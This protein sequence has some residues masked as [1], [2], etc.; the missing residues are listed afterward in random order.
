M[1]KVTTRTLQLSTKAYCAGILIDS[2]GICKD[3]APILQWMIGK[4]ERWIRHHCKKHQ[5]II[6]ETGEVDNEHGR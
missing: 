1:G 3:A 4:G 5:I 2:R 6:Q